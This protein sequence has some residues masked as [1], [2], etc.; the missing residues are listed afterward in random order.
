MIKE[1]VVS[2]KTKEK[3]QKEQSDN[4]PFIFNNVID[5]PGSLVLSFPPY[6]GFDLNFVSS[7]L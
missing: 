3:F 5:N 1:N 2:E 4:N 7:L 6:V